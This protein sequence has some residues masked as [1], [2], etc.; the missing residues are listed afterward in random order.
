MLEA[1]ECALHSLVA[2]AHRRLQA[3]SSEE[4]SGLL[5]LASILVSCQAAVLRDVSEIAL[6]VPGMLAEALPPRLFH[7]WLR[8]SAAVLAESQ[9]P[10][11]AGEAGT[12]PAACDVPGL[13]YCWCLCSCR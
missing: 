2:A 13:T 8:A 9:S 6:A 1:A 7:A 12:A 5:V 4:H 11:N 10:I 3:G